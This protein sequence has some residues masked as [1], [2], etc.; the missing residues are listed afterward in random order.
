L[1]NEINNDK[2][3]IFPNPANNEIKIIGLQHDVTVTITDVLGRTI[4]TTF[5]KN[6]SI[7]TSDINIGTYTIR[8]FINNKVVSKKF[9]K[10]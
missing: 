1:G 2:I 10:I 5:S 8:L 9:I 6:S 3:L 7:D 4:K